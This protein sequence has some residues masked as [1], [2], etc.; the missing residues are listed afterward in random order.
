MNNYLVADVLHGEDGLDTEEDRVA[1]VD[2]L[3][4]LLQLEDGGVKTGVGDGLDQDQLVFPAF[5]ALE[6]L[7]E[8]LEKV[9]KIVI[10]EN[11]IFDNIIPE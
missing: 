5:A 8:G 7:E 6:L 3:D 1:L 11:S 9:C 2:L 10:G 4:D